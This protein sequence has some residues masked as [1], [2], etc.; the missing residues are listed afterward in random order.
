M[1]AM[2]KSGKEVPTG[3]IRLEDL[4]DAGDIAALSAGWNQLLA[5]LGAQGPFLRPEWF[6]ATAASL[7]GEARLLVARR[8]GEVAGI[9]PLLVERR[10]IAGVPARVLRSMSDDHSQRFDILLEDDGIAD[11]IAAHLGKDRSWDVLELRD[12]LPASGV[13]VLAQALERAGLATGSWQSQRSPYLPLP[14]SSGELDKLLDAKFRSNIRRRARKLAED[15]GPLTLE[16]IDDPAEIDAALDDG[17]R[18]EA[19][20]WKGEAGTAIQCDPT[21]QKRYR[22]LAHRFAARGGLALIFLKAGDRRVAFH[23]A[24]LED[25]VYYLFKPGFDPTLAKYGPGH[26]LVDMVARDL[27]ARGVRELDFLGDEASWKTEWTQQVRTHTWRY[28]FRRSLMGTA[29][30]FLK[31]TV[32]PLVRRLRRRGKLET[33]NASSSTS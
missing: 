3:E 10:H 9:V 30:H 7:P 27:V 19:A 13:N 6:A 1:W 17:F 8:G 20:G 23:F 14:K 22:E 33:C 21:L 32:G 5:R 18:L 24:L 11:R 12:A 4:R 16:R 2:L 25:G 26:L 28:A 29:L 31:F 15:V